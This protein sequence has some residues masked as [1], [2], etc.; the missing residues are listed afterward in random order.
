MIPSFEFMG[1]FTF[2][3]RIHECSFIFLILRYRILSSLENSYL[4]CSYGSRVSS[5]LNFGTISNSEFIRE[6]ISS[7]LLMVRVPN[8]E[9]SLYNTH[10]LGL[11]VAQ[12]RPQNKESWLKFSLKFST[13]QTP[14]SQLP[15]QGYYTYSFP[16]FLQ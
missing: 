7:L 9:L 6:L 11:L 5:S 3:F 10:V 8:F 12:G 14:S 13:N 4:S 2:E 15:L 16:F 1:E